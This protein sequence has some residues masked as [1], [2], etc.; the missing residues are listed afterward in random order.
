MFLCRNGMQKN[1][2]ECSKRKWRAVECSVIGCNVTQE[3]VPDWEKSGAF[4]CR[5]EHDR[6]R[7]IAGVWSVMLWS[8]VESVVM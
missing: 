4:F 2:V 8:G 7:W 6:T 1:T 5:M 3:T